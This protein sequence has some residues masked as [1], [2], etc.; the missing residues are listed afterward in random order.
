MFGWL[1]RRTRSVRAL[2]LDMYEDGCALVALDQAPGGG[3]VV[4]GVRW[5]A[6]RDAADR[7]GAIRQAV[8]ELGAQGLPVVANLQHSAYTLVQ[9]EA[10]ELSDEEL[11]EA[12]R[13][14]VRDLIDF[15]IEQAVIDVF[16]LPASRR[17]GAPRLLYVVVAKASEVDALGSI[18]VAAD[19]EVTAIDVVEMAIRNLSMHLDKPARPRAYLHLQP[20]QTVIEIADGAQLYLSRRVQQEYDADADPELL[21]AQMEN[22]ALEVQRSLDYFESQYAIGAVD[23]LSVIVCN[24]TLFDAFSAVAKLFLTVPTT[25]FSFSALTVPEGT[26]MQTLGRGVTAVGAAMRGLAWV[27]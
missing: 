3:V 6:F 1:K 27:A 20:G 23:Q 14:R 24:D 9:L 4:S 22:L 12:M 11:R 8:C 18:L 17:P 16:H 7:S 10:P 5:L 19:L 13:W 2:G 25:R 15:P 26:E 21:R